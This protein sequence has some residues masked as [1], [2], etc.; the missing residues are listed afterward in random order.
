L[1]FPLL[2]FLLINGGDSVKGMGLLNVS[3]SLS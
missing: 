3:D 1:L 2:L